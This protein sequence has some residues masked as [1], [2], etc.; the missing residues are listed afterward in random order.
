MIG[1]IGILLAVVST[2]AMA[3]PAIQDA[4]VSTSPSS[5]GTVSRTLSVTPK[6]ATAVD[7]PIAY[8]LSRDMIDEDVEIWVFSGLEAAVAE[9]LKACHS[10]DDL[11][12]RLA[13]KNAETG[14]LD[15]LS[16][17]PDAPSV[18]RDYYIGVCAYYF[19]QG[20]ERQGWEHV[21]DLA[22][23]GV[24]SIDI[25]DSNFTPVRTV[26]TERLAL[27][28]QNGTKVLSMPAKAIYSRE[29]DARWAL[30][31]YGGIRFHV[32]Q[33]D[34]TRTIS[35]PFAALFKTA[36]Q[37]YFHFSVQLL[38]S[39]GLAFGANGRFVAIPLTLAIGA[40]LLPIRDESFHF[41]FRAIV[42]PSVAFVGSSP[43]ELLEVAFGGRIDFDDWGGL[44]VGPSFNVS[45]QKWSGVVFVSIG[46]R[47]LRLLAVK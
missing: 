47:L 30:G 4:G 10:R 25:V 39:Y 40:D 42:A 6:S 24:T 14:R 28:L 32:G 20:D 38:N 37:W 22:Q 7:Q 36:T 26:A 21:K 13:D 5:P 34:E 3:Q 11:R 19:Y 23:L 33:S 17:Y 16:E 2:S 43:A 35:K 46:P 41:G 1:R 31:Q 45:S 15:V 44:G 12:S 18:Y 27:W 8:T 9:A 29:A